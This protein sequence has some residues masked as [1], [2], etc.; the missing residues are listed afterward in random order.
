MRRT[1]IRIRNCS[2]QIQFDF[3]PKIRGR[4]K[5]KRKKRSSLRKG[6]SENLRRTKIRIRNC[7]TQIQSDFLPKIKERGKK[8]KKKVF[9]QKRNFRK[10]EKNKDQ[11]KKLFHPNSVRFFAQNQG[12]SKKKKE[13]KGL[14]SEKELQKI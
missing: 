3:L 1:K 4:A 9:T 7:S 14:H 12:K 6:T 5:K 2:T 10:F 13:K 11:N 8:K